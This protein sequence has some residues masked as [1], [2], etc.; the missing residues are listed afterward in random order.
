LRTD[1]GKSM[2]LVDFALSQPVLA[3]LTFI[4]LMVVGLHAMFNL[5]RDINPDVSFE[6]AII[7]TLYPGATPEDVEK[8]ITIPIEDA[9]RNVK[10][11]NRVISTSQEN[12]SEIVV[13]FTTGADIKERVRDLKDE[14]DKVNDLPEDAEDPEIFELDTSGWPAISVVLY[15]AMLPEGVMKDIAEDIQDELEDIPGI[16]S[17]ELVGTRE[18]QIL[19]SVDRAKLERHNLS[20]SSVAGAIAARNRDFPAG[21]IEM[22]REEFLVRTIGE[23]RDIREIADTIVFAGEPGNAVRVKDVATVLDTFEDP[24]TYSRFNGQP[25]VGLSVLKEKDADTHTVVRAAR[26]TVREHL[27]SIPS[28]PEVSFINDMTVLIDD[29][30]GVLKNNA[31]I[32]RPLAHVLHRFQE[33]V[34]SRPGDPVLFSAD[35]RRHA[36]D[37]NQH[38][39]H[40]RLL[41]GPGPRHRG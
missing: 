4:I 34:F 15:S 41:P 31:L 8:L 17:V 38:Q 12:I 18:R 22:D 24:A 39:R 3:N 30:L 19:V 28:A 5:P 37:G 23:Y 25:G 13:E 9:I 35:F 27:S 21:R 6:T 10:D 32:G 11:L 20:L 2:W 33:L 14:V 36:V 40:H 7:Y 26:E 16:S 29:S 1:P